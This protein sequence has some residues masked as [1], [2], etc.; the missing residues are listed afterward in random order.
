[1]KRTCVYLRE[2]EFHIG[3]F[4]SRRD[5][6]LFLILMEWHGTSRKGIDIVELERSDKPAS[7]KRTIL[8]REQFH[9]AQNLLQEAE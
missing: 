9:S 6:E 8:R 5:A 1:M 3:P 4:Y 2:G 7:T